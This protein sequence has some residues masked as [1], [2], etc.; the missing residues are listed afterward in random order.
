MKKL[1]V[2]FAV[3]ILAFAV[4]AM[5]D[6]LEPGYYFGSF[7][8]NGTTPIDLGVGFSGKVLFE[9]DIHI[10]ANITG[11]NNAVVFGGDG[12][13]DWA[14]V[15]AALYINNGWAGS[16][17][18]FYTQ[19]AKGDGQ[20]NVVNSSL[21]WKNK[22]ETASKPGYTTYHVEQT[23]D[24]AAAIEN[25]F[26]RYE[27][28]MTPEGG[29]RQLITV[30]GRHGFR[31]G[32][33]EITRF[34][35]WSNGGKDVGVSN[36]TA[37]WLEG[38]TREVT[39]NYI[40]GGE[41][42]E[43]HRFLRKAGES[44]ICPAAET[45]FYN[46]K[47]YIPEQESRAVENLSADTV[48]DIIYVRDTGQSIV[49]GYKVE[50]SELT[51]VNND[52]S[53]TYNVTAEDGA[54]KNI[55]AA[56][57]V[58]DSDGSLVNVSC[59]NVNLSETGKFTVK[60]K[61]NADDKTYRVSAMLW[62]SN[63]EPITRAKIK[64]MAGV[65]IDG[66]VS[67]NNVSLEDGMFKVSRETGM[68]Y[69]L[70]M[71]VDRLL[72]PSF[73]MAGLPAPNGAARYGGWEAKGYNGWGGA[74]FTLAGQ[75]V[76]HWMSAAAVMYSSTGNETLLE[77][78][79]Y[80][81]EKFAYI[82]E[83]TGS[84]YIGGINRA[85][86][87]SLFSGNTSS[88]SSGYWVPWYGIHKIY[89]GLIDVYTYTGNEQALDVVVKFADWA[90]EGCDKLTDSQVQTMLN[91]EYGGMNESFAQ[92]YKITGNEDYL[93]LAR[94]FT[95]DKIL[96]PL[97]QSKDE[98]TGLHANTQ[99]PKMIGA[100]EIYDNDSADYGNYKTASEFFW[101][102]VVN[103][104]SYVIGGNSIAEHFE[105]L[106]SETLGV[107]TCESCNTYNMLKLTEHLFRW[108]HKSE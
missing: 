18:V 90:K 13:K 102:A 79:N 51:A 62:G 57:A 76:G 28:Y 31:T 87:D 64:E 94:R 55:F 98:L 5:A 104:R 99:I 2:I 101:D 75:S 72:A 34:G 71:D 88:W 66:F 52:V 25:G 107:K 78:L 9:Y 85:C 68:D 91:V 80:A 22:A 27:I 7:S 32:Y 67:I 53:I 74:N 26:G 17:D 40:I 47:T 42:V 24:T 63:M 59:K 14:S 30:N 12:L 82:Q 86:F 89:Q 33:E 96:T 108:E 73:E 46:G 6:E 69:L 48:V 61:L 92:L 105:A 23:I 97:S 45:L 38:D 95:H 77:R 70:S 3:L 10:P 19:D 16:G 41:T 29:Q 21:G 4:P 35:V 37:E 43:T 20:G 39:A 58:Y 1:S 8:P 50:S 65:S 103:K 60:A 100:A 54:E 84:G 11:A 44:F 36:L 81:V 56:I 93:N 49:D 83:Q 106:G 15:G